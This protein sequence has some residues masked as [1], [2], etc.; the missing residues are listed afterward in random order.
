VKDDIRIY[1]G[2]SEH[3]QQHKQKHQWVERK[4][5]KIHKD[6]PT[7]QPVD[8]TGYRNR[9]YKCSHIH[10]YKFQY[11]QTDKLIDNLLFGI[12]CIFKN[13]NELAAI[14]ILRLFQ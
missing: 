14:N 4:N 12:A 10:F 1:H 6:I 3:E 7:V 9:D 13:C 2:D 5:L 8:S 11:V